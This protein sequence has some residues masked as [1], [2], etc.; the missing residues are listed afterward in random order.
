MTP[1]PPGKSRTNYHPSKIVNRLN[2]TRSSKTP[3]VSAHS[4]TAPHTTTSLK[5]KKGFDFHPKTSHPH[6]PSTCYP[7]EGSF[8]ADC[9]GGSGRKQDSKVLGKPLARIQSAQGP[10]QCHLADEAQPP[11]ETSMYNRREAAPQ[12]SLPRPAASSIKQK[13]V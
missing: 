1:R 7:F 9:F 2:K 6:L 3:Q 4:C 11:H 10:R 13:Q 8:T 5:R 12:P